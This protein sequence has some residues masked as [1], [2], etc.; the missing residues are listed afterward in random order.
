[1]AYIKDIKYINLAE[2]SLIVF[3][4]RKAK[5]GKISVRVN[6]TLVFT[7]FL[8]LTTRPCVLMLFDH[9]CLSKEVNNDHTRLRQLM[10]IEEFKNCL[11]TD[12]KTYIAR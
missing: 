9:Y 2:I 5:I 4:I 8:G 6:N 11:P 12:I 1:M 7:R 3:E 10:L